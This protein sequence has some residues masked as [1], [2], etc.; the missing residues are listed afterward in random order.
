VALSP[1][2]NLIA[3]PYAGMRANANPGQPQTEGGYTMGPGDKIR[4][5]VFG[6]SDLSGE[7]QLD[8]NGNVR[9]PLVGIVHAGGYTPQNLEAVVYNAL[10]P[11]YLRN[12]RL[13]VEILSYRPIYIVGQVQ[14]PGQ[15]AYVND[16]TMLNA[17][18]LAGGFTQQARESTVYV[19]HEGEAKEEEV[20]TAQ[21]LLIH[22]G[23]TVRVDTT[24]FWDAMNMFSPLSG[25]AYLASAIH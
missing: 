12:P 9:L 14:K 1:A 18:G 3:S 13:T 19:R 23:D 25:P 15:Y 21:P 5:T 6:E 22:P 20:S 16:M 4:L 17:I 24:M 2:N 8:G 11:N 7:Y 10:V